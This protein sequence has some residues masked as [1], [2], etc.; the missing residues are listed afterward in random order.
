MQ[1]SPDGRW[2]YVACNKNREVLEID[3]A[4]WEVTRRFSTGAGPY[5]L[6]V[7]PDG[8]TLVVTYKGDE[9]VGVFDL[10]TGKERAAVESTRRIPHGVVVSPDSRYA[11]VSIEGVGGEPGT[12][13]VIHLESGTRVG[14]ADMGK[15]AGG[16]GFWKVEAGS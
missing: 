13:D 2:A 11:F 12:V 16:I 9:A 6:D 4:A 5:N 1:P 8:E 10:A 3:L 15:Q 14:S 7:T